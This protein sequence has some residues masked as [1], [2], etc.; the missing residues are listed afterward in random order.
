MIKNK[1][2]VPTYELLTRTELGLHSN[3]STVLYM[4]FIGLYG[5]LLGNPT[6]TVP[7]RAWHEA[8]SQD[9]P[10]LLLPPFLPFF[11]LAQNQFR[12]FSK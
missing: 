1:G 5:L 7:G 9:V 10:L 6:G 2:Q 4:Y 11:L 8:L 3:Y 12:A